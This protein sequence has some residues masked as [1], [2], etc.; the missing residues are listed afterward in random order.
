MGDRARCYDV[1]VNVVFFVGADFDA[2]PPLGTTDRTRHVKVTTVDEAQ[3]PKLR[4]W[5]EE[6]SRMPGWT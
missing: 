4:N 5:I 3:Q 1:S 6:A 2:P